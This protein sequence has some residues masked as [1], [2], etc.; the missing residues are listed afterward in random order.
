[1]DIVLRK[2][3]LKK[4]LL[5]VC[6]LGSCIGAFAHDGQDSGINS[7]IDWLGHQQQSDGSIINHQDIALPF[8]ATFEAAVTMSNQGVLSRIDSDLLKQ[9][10][11]SNANASSEFYSKLLTI[12]LKLG[13]SIAQEEAAL[14]TFQNIDG[15]FGH[16]SG[17]D[18]TVF[19]TAFVLNAVALTTKKNSL[20]TGQ[21]IAYLLEQQNPDGSFEDSSYSTAFLTSY[22][23]RALQPYLYTFN[24]SDQITKARDFLFSK[25]ES[26]A[27]W[28][29]D[30][31]AAHFLLAVVPLTTDVEQY[32][33]SLDWLKLQQLQ[34]GSWQNDVY[35]SALALQAL[36]LSANITFPTSPDTALVKGKLLDGDSGQALEGVEI[37][38]APDTATAVITDEAGEFT[39]TGL[40][41]NTYTLSYQVPGYVS[42]S[43]VLT[44]KKGQLIDLGNIVLQL[45]PTTAVVSGSVVEAVSGLPVANVLIE[46]VTA[47]ETVTA[48]TDA[49]GTYS[50]IAPAG[51][52]TLKASANDYYP[53]SASADIQ[54][55]TRVS[56]SPSLSKLTEEP[57]PLELIGR[58][59]DVDSQQP[60]A[61]VTVASTELATEVTTDNEG[62][63]SFPG[64]PTGDQ[65]FVFSLQG[66]QSVI[67]RV[68]LPQNGKID[69]GT[70]ELGQLEEL[71]STSVSGQVL[72]ADTGLGVEGATV[73]AAGLSAQ[74][75]ATG[76]YEITGIQTLEFDVGANAQGYVFSSMPVNIA[77][78]GKLSIT[79]DLYR[80]DISGISVDRVDTAHNQYQA[81][82][83]VDVTAIV[84]N[85]TVRE[86]GVRLYVLVKD[87]QENTID[88][89]PAVDIP[90]LGDASDPESLAHYEQHLE[91][92]VEKFAPN[93]TRA[94][95]LEMSWNTGLQQP[96]QY[97]IVVQ[98]LDSVNSQVLSEFSTPFEVLPTQKLTSA[99]ASVSPGYALLDSTPEIALL[100]N[101]KNA[102]NETASSDI[103]YQLVS[104][105]GQTIA[106]GSQTVQLT[107]EELTKE[108]VLSQL[109]HQFTESGDY[110]VTISV[111]AGVVPT[112]LIN[113]VLFV[114][115]TVRLDVS[116]DIE[117]EKVLPGEQR[118]IEVQIKV[119]GVDG[120]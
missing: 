34:N 90:L 33:P 117:P 103:A 3:V 100:L 24:I 92:A 55:G 43:Q 61:G 16:Q 58:V 79:L 13:E 8:Q 101:L 81:Y 66:Y 60:L 45:A 6:L 38:I 30:W 23:L 80:A 73:S 93:E 84:S 71:Q 109:S 35:S 12:K 42:A 64:V 56:F 67:T 53:V 113:G 89:F 77:S 82:E 70:V 5:M 97:S 15:G 47:Q 20:E 32:K 2:L 108:V 69:I 76:H 83:Q 105:T 119:E 104:P 25:V 9:F 87:A 99:H 98:A 110:Q 72:D 102:S 50:L 40:Q 29:T 1:M 107:P 88:S 78:H 39:F 85:Q 111:D 62:N 48:L 28:P 63:F 27:D 114:P 36:Y 21:A 91:D 52:V 18:S 10:V 41:P 57:Q 49:Q 94:I 44:T 118:T 7:G 54:A 51:A 17:F 26:G 59:V 4:L 95:E 112:A 116:Q 120:E 31:E 22:V 37:G 65:G 19:D 74:T 86:R 46:I 75:S 115:P 96:G 14:W 68:A 106:Q 11:I